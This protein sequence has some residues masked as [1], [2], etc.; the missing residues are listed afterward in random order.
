MRKQLLVNC[1]WLEGEYFLGKYGIYK[2]FL[3]LL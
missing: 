1:R 2:R 3:N